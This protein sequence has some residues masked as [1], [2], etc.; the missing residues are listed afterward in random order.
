LSLIDTRTASGTRF[1]L[2]VS[3]ARIT[4]TH[5]AVKHESF[6]S[7]QPTVRARLLYPFV[8]V[9]LSP[10]APSP[11]GHRKAG[12]GRATI[13]R[14]THDHDHS[15]WW[16]RDRETHSSWRSGFYSSYEAYDPSGPASFDERDLRLT[17]RGGARISAAEITAILER[18]VKIERA[19][20][21]STLMHR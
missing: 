15:S 16:R 7:V 1:S 21:R 20:T 3:Y 18:R 12:L 13:V 4:V 19:C 17:N 14:R 6:C 8:C 2:T 5:L 10:A 9:R 11:A